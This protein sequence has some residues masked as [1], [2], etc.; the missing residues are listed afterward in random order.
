MLLIVFLPKIKKQNYDLFDVPDPDA[1]LSFAVLYDA[2]TRFRNRLYDLK[3][4][5]SVRFDIPVICVGNLSVG[6]TGKTP[7]IEYLIKL[8]VTKHSLA[9]LSRGYMRKTKGFRIANPSETAS[10]LGDEPFQLYRK[11]G[12]WITVAVGEDRAMAIPNILQE[13][14][15]VDLI[16]LDDGFQ[17]RRV[18]PSF[19]IVLTE[20]G[21]PFYKDFLLPTGR[22]RESRSNANRANAI[23]VTKCP[24]DIGDNTMETIR[25]EIG[26]Y[27]QH[28]VFFTG[29]RYGG[30]L[31]FGEHRYEKTSKVV[32]VT[33]IASTA[34][35]RLF[36]DTHFVLVEHLNFSDHHDY[37]IADLEK[38][39]AALKKD[40]SAI[41]LTT[42]KDMVKLLDSRFDS[43]TTRLPFFYLPIEVEFVKDGKKFDDLVLQSTEL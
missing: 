15:T 32:L 27:T 26:R 1:A 42:E 34:A 14:S 3:V 17:H 31:P 9:V 22:L 29:I 38:I 40:V 4:K 18:S 43:F 30:L 16:L 33:G 8:L 23:I 20:Y 25:T 35:L 2:V 41:I 39:D 7:V 37:T 10:T 6:G 13:A 21:N 19:S 11:F 36:V 28:P 24:L 5:P 12:E